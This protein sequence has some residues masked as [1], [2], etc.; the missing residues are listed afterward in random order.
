V[1][2]AY[3]LLGQPEE[4]I[5]EFV[6]APGPMGWRYFAHVH[7]P[8]DPGHDRLTVDL[9]TDLEWNVVR[10]RLVSADG[11]GAMATGIDSGLEVLH[12]PS[13]E[14]RLDRFDQA[15]AVWSTS[16][17]AL[18]V[19]RRRLGFGGGTM[20]A[21]HI[22]IGRDPSSVGVSLSD[23]NPASM[24]APAGTIAPIE[25]TVDGRRFEAS[26]QGDMPVAAEGWFVL[27]DPK[28]P[29]AP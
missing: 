22:E 28:G 24:G 16:P 4:L 6:A 17:S 3:R 8:D 5:E 26:M 15:S 25:V 13:G 19:A 7:P 1:Q 21:V 20:G 29:P 11:W 27:V 14:E 23:A 12:G 10:F 18:L 9:V 2:G